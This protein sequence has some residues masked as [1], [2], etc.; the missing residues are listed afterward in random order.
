MIFGIIGTICSG[1]DIIA[2]YLH[3]HYNFEKINLMEIYKEKNPKIENFINSDED[4]DNVSD[5]PINFF[6]SIFLIFIS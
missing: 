6:S 3:D 5:Y 2:T 1:K 4:G